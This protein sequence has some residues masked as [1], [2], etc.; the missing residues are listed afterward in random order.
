ME[1][2]MSKQPNPS[3]GADAE[4]AKRF[5][6]I[7]LEYNLEYPEDFDPMLAALIAAAKTGERRLVREAVIDELK[8]L[9]DWAFEAFDPSSK[10]ATVL[11]EIDDRIA[12]LQA[13]GE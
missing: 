7:M 2:F 8:E 6:T 5:R 12:Q 11:I 1:I 10:A 13:E 3:Q 4:L 9:H